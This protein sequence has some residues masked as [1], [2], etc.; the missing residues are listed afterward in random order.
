MQWD[1]S[2]SLSACPANGSSTK[3]DTKR[4]QS[5]AQK[6]PSGPEQLSSLQSSWPLGALT[7]SWPCCRHKQ[8][9][10]RVPGTPEAFHEALEAFYKLHGKQVHTPSVD[11]QPLDLFQL[12]TSVAARGG[13]EVVTL[14]RCAPQT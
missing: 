8:Y 4:T 2:L 3:D 11:K 13:Y 14:E 6:T 1:T 7:I 10:D 5:S 9:A 12:F